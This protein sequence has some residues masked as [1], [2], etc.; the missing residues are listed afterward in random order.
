MCICVAYNILYMIG[1]CLNGKFKSI[2]TKITK[3]KAIKTKRYNEMMVLVNNDT[4]IDYH[5]RR[6]NLWPG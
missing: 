6:E 2:Y 4:V 5:W 3:I 1:W